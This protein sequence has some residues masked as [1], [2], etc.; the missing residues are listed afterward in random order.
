M[1][2]CYTCIQLRAFVDTFQRYSFHQFVVRWGKYCDSNLCNNEIVAGP[3]PSTL[4]VYPRIQVRFR[5]TLGSSWIHLWIIFLYNLWNIDSIKKCSSMSKN[6]YTLSGMR[7]RKNVSILTFCSTFLVFL[8]IVDDFYTS[9]FVIEWVQDFV[10]SRIP[11]FLV[12]KAYQLLE[13]DGF[14]LSL[15]TCNEIMVLR[16]L[17]YTKHGPCKQCLILTSTGKVLRCHFSDR[18]CDTMSRTLRMW[19]HPALSYRSVIIQQVTSDLKVFARLVMSWGNR[20]YLAT[21]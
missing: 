1:G 3:C 5:R 16:R 12:H 7:I 6:V 14:P 8:V 15:S 21:R 2:A 11:L 4:Q 19:K 17:A 13:I 18:S 20:T 9:F 10:E